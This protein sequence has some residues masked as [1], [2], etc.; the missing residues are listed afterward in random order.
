MT[1]SGLSEVG[2]RGG[3]E[4]EEERAGVTSV[5]DEEG[6]ED[7]EGEVVRPKLSQVSAALDTIEAFLLSAEGCTKNAMSAFREV[8]SVVVREGRNT[9]K[10][11]TI[12]VFFAKS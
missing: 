4:S 2:E 7:V 5:E 11:K 8:E 10:Q 12:D 1:C 3:V 9:L 6:N